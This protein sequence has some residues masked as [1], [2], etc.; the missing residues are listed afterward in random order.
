MVE[1]LLLHRQLPFIALHAALDAV[2]QIGSADPAL[3]AIEARRMADGRGTSAVTVDRG[4]GRSGWSRPLP[5]LGGYDALIGRGA[6][7]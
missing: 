3:V 4:E 6:L 1:V 5:V 7:R 2:E